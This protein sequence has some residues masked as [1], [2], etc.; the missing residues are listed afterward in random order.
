MNIF[1][2]KRVNLA[3]YRVK[4]GKKNI[5]IEVKTVFFVF[6]ENIFLIAVKTVNGF[7]VITKTFAK[8]IAEIEDETVKSFIKKAMLLHDIEYDEE[9][10]HFETKN[11][12]DFREGVVRFLKF[13]AIVE[14]LL[15]FNKK[16]E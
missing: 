6:D 3:T 14:F 4:P 10:G 2:I 11:L 5:T 15:S 12:I 7:V 13:Y 8:K 16:K 1:E 9:R